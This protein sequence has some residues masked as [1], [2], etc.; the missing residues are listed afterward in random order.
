[1]PHINMQQHCT[2]LDL[3]AIVEKLITEESGKCGETITE[4]LDLKKNFKICQHFQTSFFHLNEY[5]IYLT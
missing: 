1:M 3:W 4:S 5:C 2:F